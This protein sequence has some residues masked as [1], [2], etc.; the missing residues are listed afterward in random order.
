LDVEMPKGAY[1]TACAIE[2]DPVHKLCVMLIP[3]GHSARMQV[4]LFRYDP[5]TAKYRTDGASPAPT[6]GAAGEPDT[7]V[8]P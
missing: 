8:E 4:V 7:R 6:G 2:Y 3:P 1:G 5:K